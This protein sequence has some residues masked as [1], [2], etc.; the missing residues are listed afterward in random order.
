MS[1]GGERAVRILEWVAGVL[2]FFISDIS[3]RPP[4]GYG[5]R[6]LERCYVLMISISGVVLVLLVFY[7]HSSV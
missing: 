7:L 2:H 5:A 4:R 3:R 1:P 6:Y